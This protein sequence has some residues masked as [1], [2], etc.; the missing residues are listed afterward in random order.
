[1]EVVSLF[2]TLASDGLEERV[3]FDLLHVLSEPL[4]HHGG[5]LDP[6]IRY[7]ILGATG[8]NESGR[9]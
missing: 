2:E 9:E 4:R 6:P 5:W 8:G 3:R 7:R 1:M